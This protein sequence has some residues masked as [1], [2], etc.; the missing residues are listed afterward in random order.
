MSK[1]FLPFLIVLFFF[2][3]FVFP[4][5]FIIRSVPRMTGFLLLA[6][7]L[8]CAFLYWFIQGWQ[9]FFSRLRLQSDEFQEK[10]NVSQTELDRCQHLKNSLTKRIV[11]FKNLER[12]SEHLNAETDLDNMCDRIARETFFL[13]GSQGSV[14]LYL[15]NEKNHR[16]GLRAIANG[17]GGLK[18]KEKMGDL[19][20][21]WVLRHNQ[22]L[23]VEDIFSDFR[24]D[25][26]AVK[27]GLSRPVGSLITAPLLTELS[28]LG[29][30]RVE[31]LE[32]NSY[33]SDDLRFLAVVADIAKLSLENA[34]YVRHMEE[35]SIHDGLTGVYLRRYAMDR[36]KEEFLRMHRGESVLSFLMFDIDH[37]KGFN[38][39]YGH[40][41]GD[42]VLKKLAR[43]LK[44][45][46]DMPGTVI[47]RYG[48]EE[49][50]VTL[51]HVSKLEAIRL[52]ESFCQELRSR[53][54]I[55]RREKVRVTVSIGVAAAPDDAR[56]RQGL[57]YQ[58]DEALLKAKREGR[59]RVCC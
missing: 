44:D 42:V 28:P 24:F 3:F 55:L 39:R 27:E 59:D 8:Y 51:P 22:A 26:D 38:D 34:L 52:A 46:F 14:L 20:D 10:A 56:D 11:D 30:L 33:H 25:P 41:A 45:F 9:R 40:M 5:Y 2:V 57:I 21:K 50:C 13:F 58:A 18:I 16:L 19:F 29:I 15:V 47:A 23:L 12:F 1:K 6:Y 53:E 48:G 49:F 37:F 36:L 32:T 4:P 31:S 43:V 7:L 17:S 54:I 35:L